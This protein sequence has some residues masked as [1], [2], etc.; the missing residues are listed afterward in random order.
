MYPVL[1]GING[2][3]YGDF[4]ECDLEVLPRLMNMVERG[5]LENRRPPVP[6]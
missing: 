5:V 6:R 1:L 3:G 4:T 2:M